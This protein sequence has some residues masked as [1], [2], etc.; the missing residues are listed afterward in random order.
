VAGARTIAGRLAAAY[1]RPLPS[2][3][4]AVMYLFPR[5]ASLAGVDPGE[6]PMPASRARALVGLCAALAE[7]DLVLDG[8]AER[9]EVEERLLGLP[10]VGPWTAGYIRMRA[11]R[12]PD[13]W[14]GTDLEVVKALARLV[15]ASGRAPVDPAQW[16]PW[17][18]YAVLHLWSGGST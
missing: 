13:V 16:S 3:C 9:A 5:A 1:G 2:P 8:S 14:L 12:D 11:L 4:G 7:G 18:S 10:G 17:R 15:S 6:L